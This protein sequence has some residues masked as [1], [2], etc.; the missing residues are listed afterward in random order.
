[1]DINSVWSLPY[2]LGYDGVPNFNQAF[3]N[4]LLGKLEKTTSDGFHSK[5]TATP[6]AT[7]PWDCP[8]PRKRP[9][10][11]S[12]TNTSPS[13]ASEKPQTASH[14]DSIPSQENN[15]WTGDPK[16]LEGTKNET[17][18]VKNNEQKELNQE[19]EKCSEGKR[20]VPLQCNHIQCQIDNRTNV[21]QCT[22]IKSRLSDDTK[23][24]GIIS[25]KELS[26]AKCD[27]TL[28][29]Q[30]EIEKWTLE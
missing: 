7:F 1:M 24:C 22:T 26:L 21:C 4:F 27:Q 2:F 18:K 6:A 5:Q 3:V 10:M 12:A 23:G 19:N 11:I 29:D 13:T 17:E 20:S 25:N 30:S 9:A 16:P 15:N 8:V 14:G 28:G